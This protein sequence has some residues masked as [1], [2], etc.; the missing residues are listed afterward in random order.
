MARECIVNLDQIQT[1]PQKEIGG[2]VTRLSNDRMERVRS[3]LLFAL[4]FHGHP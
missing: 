1:V 4:G 2:L 3:A